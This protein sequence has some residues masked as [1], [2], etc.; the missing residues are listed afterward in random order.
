VM[1][2][3][4]ASCA[5]RLWMA[6]DRATRRRRLAARRLRALHAILSDPSAFYDVAKQVEWLRE[7]LKAW[8]SHFNV[9]VSS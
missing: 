2:R 8:T 1:G 4:V 7:G 6:P 5:A 3:A 9:G